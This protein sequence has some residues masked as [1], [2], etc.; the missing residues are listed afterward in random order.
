MTD[1]HFEIFYLLLYG[2][3]CCVRWRHPKHW[4]PTKAA[5]ENIV[6][7]YLDNNLSQNSLLAVETNFGLI[8]K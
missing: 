7:I 2:N 6:N 3:D 1:M 4:L 5:N 8:W